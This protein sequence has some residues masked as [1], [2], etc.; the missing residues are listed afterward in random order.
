MLGETGH[1][2]QAPESLKDLVWREGEQ[3]E[4]AFRPGGDSEELG[5]G[6]VCAWWGRGGADEGSYVSGSSSGIPHFFLFLPFK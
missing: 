4:Q 5:R 1:P 6:R 3:I 2:G